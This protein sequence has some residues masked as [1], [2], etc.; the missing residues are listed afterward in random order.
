M[1]VNA[2]SAAHLRHDQLRGILTRLTANDR[3]GRAVAAGRDRRR[4]TFSAGKAAWLSPNRTNRAAAQ[5]GAR[6][7]HAV[8][9]RS[10]FVGFFW[11]RIKTCLDSMRRDGEAGGGKAGASDGRWLGRRWQIPMEKAV[12]SLAIRIIAEHV[13]FQ[14]NLA[15]VA[16]NRRKHR[17]EQP[18]EPFRQDAVV[19]VF[20]LT[21]QFDEVGRAEQR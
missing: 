15:L 19:I 9:R 14:A 10:S 7:R 18:V 21:A 16:R 13:V 3:P 1:G 20:A 2:Q 5:I 8:G 17:I 12:R 11:E 6:L 4:L